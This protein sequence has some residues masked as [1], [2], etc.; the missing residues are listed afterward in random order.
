MD[1]VTGFL[2]LLKR[3][4]GKRK[5]PMMHSVVLA[6]DAGY[7]LVRESRSSLKRE[8]IWKL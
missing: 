3:K 4:G 1:F 7:L 8:S 5:M 6:H 2:K